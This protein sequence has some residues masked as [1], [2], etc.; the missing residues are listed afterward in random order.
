MRKILLEEG[1]VTWEQHQAELPELLSTVSRKR[2]NK[3]VKGQAPFTT[4]ETSQNQTGSGITISFQKQSQIW[5]KE[6]Q[7]FPMNNIHV[8][9]KGKLKANN[10]Y[11][12]YNTLGDDHSDDEEFE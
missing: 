1:F 12:R 8:E 6:V 5:V 7:K 11:H 9:N 2:Q 10:R 4:Q 3:Q